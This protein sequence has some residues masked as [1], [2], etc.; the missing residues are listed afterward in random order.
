MAIQ[1]LTANFTEAE[2]DGEI[3]LM[4]LDNGELL[5]LADSGAAIWRLLDRE[6]DRASMVA[7]LA[8]DYAAS[9]DE[10]ERDLDELLRELKEAGLIEES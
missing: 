5:S 9:P 10:I 8:A 3:M 6:C 4:R 2:F 1:K 7:N